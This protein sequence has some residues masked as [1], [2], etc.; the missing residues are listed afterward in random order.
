MIASLAY[1]MRGLEH[2]TSHEGEYDNTRVER[3]LDP[4]TGEPVFDAQKIN[5]NFD[6]ASIASGVS[7]NWSA[8]GEMT[9][10]ELDKLRAINDK[11]MASIE[12]KYRERM[13]SIK[14]SK[15]IMREAKAKFETKEYLKIPSVNFPS[16]GRGLPDPDHTLNTFM[17]QKD[18]CEDIKE[19]EN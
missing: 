7:Y 10:D 1:G 5:Q 12:A 16:Y 3:R 19:K 4:T 18:M 15:Q 9:N 8:V 13:D 2:L 14:N 11:K 6:D 17:V